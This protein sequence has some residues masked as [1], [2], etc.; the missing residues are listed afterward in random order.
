M[1]DKKKFEVINHTADIG[2]K[3]FGKNICHLLENAAYGMYS[4]LCDIKKIRNKH[5]FK[6]TFLEKNDFELVLVTFLNRLLYHTSTK[7]FL[8]KKFIVKINHLSNKKDFVKV[9][10]ECYGE[11]YCS[12]K[13]GPLMEI[14]AVTYHNLKIVKKNKNN[15]SGT[16]FFD[17]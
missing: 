10:A 3:V 9:I 14:K 2:L 7:F 15:F 16:V 17:I 11:K 8:F 5:L 12:K 1:L 13:H 4:L 6:I